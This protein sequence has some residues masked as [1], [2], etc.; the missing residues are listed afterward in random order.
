[1]NFLRIFR[2]RVLTYGTSSTA[3][4]ARIRSTP[5]R[6]GTKRP[7]IPTIINVTPAAMRRAFNVILKYPFM[8][9]KKKSRVF[10]SCESRYKKKKVADGMFRRLKEE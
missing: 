2:K 4:P 5:C 6:T 10:K 3:Q 9:R 1:M 8:R 7:I